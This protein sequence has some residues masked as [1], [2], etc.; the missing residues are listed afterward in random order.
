MKKIFTVLLFCAL[1]SYSQAQVIESGTAAASSGSGVV[2]G[3][4]PAMAGGIGVSTATLVIGTSLALASGV[5]IATSS[6][7]DNNN[8]TGTTGTK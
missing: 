1:S 6:K 5:A 2:S 7:N 8:T 3:S 4:L